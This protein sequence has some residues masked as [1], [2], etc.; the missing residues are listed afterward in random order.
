MALVL[1][2]LLLL[3]Y[4][5]IPQ[6]VAV[7]RE[8]W[9]GR[10]YVA[11]LLHKS[12]KQQDVRRTFDRL[13]SG[14]G[15]NDVVLS[16]ALTSWPVPSSNGKIVAALHYE[17]FVPDQSSRSADVAHFFSPSES[18]ADQIGILDKYA[19]RWILLNRRVLS[20]AVFNQL[21]D[22]SAVVSREK[23]LYLMDAETWRRGKS[24]HVSG[25]RRASPD[26]AN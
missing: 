22:P 9:L 21:L 11:R 26:S 19:A 16:D 15:T 18:K 14:V 2:V 13:L 12:D 25:S 6:C 24:S 3:A 8:P 23:D 1:A 10:V 5:L 20:V 17:L 7:F 4:G